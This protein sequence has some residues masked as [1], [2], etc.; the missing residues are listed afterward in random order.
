MFLIVLHI[1]MKVLEDVKVVL[2][3]DA[4]D[5]WHALPSMST[6]SIISSFCTLELLLLIHIY[7]Y[8]FIIF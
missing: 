2:F 4:C 8:L 1:F 3:G 7:I 6:D 5:L